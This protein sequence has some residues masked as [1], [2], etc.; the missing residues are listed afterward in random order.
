MENELALEA[1][2]CRQRAQEYVGRA[3]EEFLL[4]LA[5]TFDEL[6]Q[7]SELLIIHSTRDAHPSARP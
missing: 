5:S 2:K 1:L 7:S 3:E 6:A 4:K